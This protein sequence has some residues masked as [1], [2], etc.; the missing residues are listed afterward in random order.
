MQDRAP[1]KPNRYAV[2]DD[3][4]NF[5]RYEYHERADE[6]TQEGDALNK[7]NLLPDEVAT[8]LGLTGN[9]QVKDALTQLFNI[10]N[11]KAKIATSSY[12]GTGTYGAD[13]PCSLTFPFV[14]RLILVT[15]TETSNFLVP[16]NTTWQNGFVWVT[17]AA[18]FASGSAIS[19]YGSNI[20]TI[21]GNTFSWY[22]PGTSTNALN[23]CNVSGAKYRCLAIG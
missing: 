20:V 15:R 21:S 22:S 5:L 16:A 9:P 3:A 7:A 23:Q 18:E 4:H 6:P 19:N 1:T 10:A 8:A 2:Y 13:N 12:T 11:P 14:P 17:G